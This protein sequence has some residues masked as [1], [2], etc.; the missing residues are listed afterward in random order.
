MRPHR[1]P[2]KSKD[3]H[4]R[5]KGSFVSPGGCEYVVREDLQERR[6]EIYDR[7]EGRCQLNI[8][9]FHHSGPLNAFQ[10]ELHHRRRHGLTNRCYCPENLCVACRWCHH[11]FHVKSRRRSA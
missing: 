4:F 2:G 11:W 9:P 10:W 5:D 1:D 6:Q 8:S 7:D 3:R